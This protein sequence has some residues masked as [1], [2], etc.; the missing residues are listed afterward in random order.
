LNT[1]VAQL[2]VEG[3]RAAQ[4]RS[5]TE[6]IRAREVF[7]RAVELDDEY[8]PAHAGLANALTLL[9]V[10]AVNRPGDVLP[11]AQARARRAVEL[12]PTFGFGWHT[13]AH[14]QVH[15]S[16]EWAE[17]E[18]NY[19]R[20][21]ALDPMALASHFLLA[22]LLVGLGRVDEAIAESLEALRLGP[23]VAMV[24]TSAGIVHY[25]ARRPKD[26]TAYLNRA[27]ELD[28]EYSIAS[29]WQAL[30][31]VALDRFDEAMGAALASRAEMGNAPTWLV[32]YVHARAGR[33]TEARAVLDALEAH[34]A[35]H[36]VPALE[37]A[38]LH[39][40]LGERD[41]GL[42]WLEHAVEEHSRWTEL[43][44][45]DPLLDPLRGEP[46]FRAL[47]KTMGLEATP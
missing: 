9:H 8:A 46:R 42:T 43:M 22:H 32:G 5:Q 15:W 37:F 27:R 21:Q 29:F 40:A 19:R 1:T 39:M 17:A 31:L 3:N 6:L 33:P 2:M 38:Y 34:A 41:A 14:S 12:D 10:F 35:N 7:Q 24:Q 13:L 30:T 16:R 11:L 23:T 47:L 26:A 45:V 28:P 18:S 36:Y 4:R 25:F 44:A 20:A